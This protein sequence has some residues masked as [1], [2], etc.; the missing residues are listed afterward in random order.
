M[1]GAGESRGWK[2]TLP[3]V[4][5]EGFIEEEEEPFESNPRRIKSSSPGAEEGKVQH[6]QSLGYGHSLRVSERWGDE[7]RWER[8]W[9]PSQDSELILR[10]LG[11][12]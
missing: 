6:T 12:P 10:S 7:V 2:M 8:L 4:G 1:K 9:L 3:G 5:G 11:S